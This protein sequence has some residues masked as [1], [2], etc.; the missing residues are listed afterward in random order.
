MIYNMMN[1]FSAYE[2]KSI[3]ICHQPGRPAGLIF[4]IFPSNF[5]LENCLPKERLIRQL[6]TKV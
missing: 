1:S 3:K 6:E 4:Q 5:R 2:F